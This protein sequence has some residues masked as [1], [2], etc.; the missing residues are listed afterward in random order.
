[1]D[2]QRLVGSQRVSNPLPPLRNR[3]VSTRG[4]TRG[5]NSLAGRWVSGGGEATAAAVTTLERPVR[6]GAKTFTEQYILATLI[7]MRLK[8]A[9]FETQR[10]DGLGSTVIF[11]ALA[12]GELDVYV[13]YSGT[14]WA[15]HLGRP[16]ATASSSCG[17]SARG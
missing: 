6:I 12:D 2:T 3:W 1:M 9:G 8:A 10:I 11:D 5:A 4:A 14:I 7:E 15:N 13:D 16:S 17:S